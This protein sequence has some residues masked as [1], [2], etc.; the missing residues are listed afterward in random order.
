MYLSLPNY[1]CILL[2][3]FFA[4]FREFTYLITFTSLY[5][6]ITSP[7]GAVAKYCHEYVCVCVS[8]CVFRVSA[9]L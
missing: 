2:F 5:F 4:L 6:I 1:Y 9:I 7:V 8:V 3:Y